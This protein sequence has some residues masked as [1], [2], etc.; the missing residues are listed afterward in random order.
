MRR[1]NSIDRV[2][3]RA[4]WPWVW[5]LVLAAVAA[6][7]QPAYQVRWHPVDTVAGIRPTSPSDQAADPRLLEEHVQAYRTQLQVEG[8]LLASVDSMAW[9]DSI[10]HAWLY[11]GPQFRWVNLRN[12]NVGSDFLSAAGYRERTFRDRPFDR[13]GLRRLQEN[14]LA[15][16]ENNGYPFAIVRLDSL[17]ID[18]DGGLSAGLYLDAG[19]PMFFDS[20][21]VSGD[22]DISV[23]YLQRYLGIRQGA[24]YSREKVRRTRDRLRELPF[25]QEQRSATVTFWEDQANLQLYLTRRQASRLDFLLGVLPDNNRPE[26]A[27][28]VTGNFKADFQNPFGKGERIYIA[29]ERLRPQTQRLDLAFAYPYLLDM[30]FG[31]DLR[32]NQ[33]KRDSTYTDIISET[34]VQYL[35]EG[36]NYLKGFWNRTQSR[37]LAVDTA[38]IRQGRFPSQLDVGISAYGLEAQWQQLDYRFNPRSGWSVWVRA[39][40]GI[41][42]VRR[43]PAILGAAADFYDSLVLRTARYTAEIRS[44]AYLPLYVRSTLRCSF[45]AGTLLSG[46]PLYRNEQYRI[47]GNNLLRGFDEESIFATLFGVF[48]LEYRLLTGQNSWFYLFG[49]YGY[50]EDRR[51]GAPASFGRWP[52][53]G[54]GLT[55]DTAAGVFGL[56]M[57]VGQP[58]GGTWQWRNP[59]VH[60]GYVSL[61]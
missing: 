16:A 1:K 46:S 57:A 19:R 38:A 29:F 42:Q 12:G 49:D 15:E 11:R 6:W 25:L 48:S 21:T 32:F 41:R 43:N 5:G 2:G 28:L 3:R 45:R 58:S 17:D 33:Y 55:L 39:S 10:L 4:R 40:A 26:T 27:L 30:P 44:E 24:P 9:E 22:V 18:A 35:L 8:W 61:F 50:T 36:G 52:S 34:G 54:A 20:L 23:R 37:L 53:V 13:T 47:G 59:K 14:L 60:F 7:A 56:G 31:L 51:S